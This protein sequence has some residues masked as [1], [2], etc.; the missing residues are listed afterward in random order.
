MAPRTVTRLAPI[1]QRSSRQKVMQSE[2]TLTRHRPVKKAGAARPRALDDGL[3][4][5]RQIRDARNLV[6][7]PNLGA[8]EEFRSATILGALLAD[9]NPR[10]LA[11]STDDRGLTLPHSAALRGRVHF[12]AAILRAGCA[13]T[14]PPDI[15]PRFFPRASERARA[16][17]A[18]LGKRWPEN[19]R[20]VHELRF[21]T[22]AVPDDLAVFLRSG[23]D[24]L[25][26]ERRKRKRALVRYLYW[27]RRR[28]ALGTL[29]LA[30]APELAEPESRLAP[31]GDRPP[32]PPAQTPRSRTRQILRRSGIRGGAP[33]PD[34]RPRPSPEIAK[35]LE[36]RGLGN[37]LALRAPSP[38]SPCSV[39]EAPSFEAAAAPRRD[40]DARDLECSICLELLLDPVA[41]GLCGH[42]F[43]SGCIAGALR[44]ARDRRCPLC[45]AKLPPGAAPRCSRAPLL[46]RLA[47]ARGDAPPAPP[48]TPWLDV[49]ILAVRVA[50]S[51][52]GVEQLGADLR[53]D[54]VPLEEIRARS[55]VLT[56]ALDKQELAF[57]VAIFAHPDCDR[58]LRNMICA[59]L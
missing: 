54:G 12:L 44:L 35:W 52:R 13:W 20:D 22:I 42:V 8:G 19:R 43:C 33:P 51:F 24:G 18:R 9:V 5:A 14:A 40:E 28:A 16:A 50:S 26:K 23:A 7:A 11:A 3:R 46:A 29:T 58:H 49:R 30:G 31:A 59:F 38:R 55:S 15:D 39:V 56:A 32:S 1:R 10:S 36:R 57:A 34:D 37:I 2:L 4:V 45:R 27:I 47:A 41:P 17:C 48:A 21:G 6:E 53:S 25:R